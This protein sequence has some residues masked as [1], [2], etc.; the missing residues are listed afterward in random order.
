MKSILFLFAA[1]CFLWGCGTNNSTTPTAKDAAGI[2]TDSAADNKIFFPVA[3]F[4]GGQIRQI[5]SLQ[6]PLTESITRNNK[7]ALGGITDQ[8]FKTL[9]AG[10]QHPDI[11]DPAL[12]K[13][14]RE[15]SFA[16]QSIPSV[17]FTYATDN[18]GLELQK[19]DVIV[20]PDP[21]Q[22][23]KVNTIYLEKFFMIKDTSVSQKLYWKAG[24]NF[25]IITEK[26]TGNTVLPVELVKVTWD[27]TE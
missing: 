17:T 1:S 18:P 7:T 20:K 9:A 13:Y 4:I 25:Q 24:K 26:K 15:T 10:F 21:V 8:D 2:T 16:D 11:N 3:D 5:D 19:I 14:Y 27:P 22:N 12:K 23:D 6:L